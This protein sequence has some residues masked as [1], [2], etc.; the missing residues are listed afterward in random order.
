MKEPKRN[1]WTIRTRLDSNEFRLL[2][3]QKIS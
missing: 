3:L 1:F 2:I